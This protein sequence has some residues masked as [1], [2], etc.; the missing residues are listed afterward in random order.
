MPSLLDRW[1]NCI[2][3]EDIEETKQELKE[4]KS[5]AKGKYKHPV[6][7]EYYNTV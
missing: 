7:G 3:E 5:K 2:D 1:Y 6:T 4:Q